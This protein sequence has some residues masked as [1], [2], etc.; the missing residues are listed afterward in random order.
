M[1][2]ISIWKILV[3]QNWIK[4]IWERSIVKVKNH[5]WSQHEKIDFFFSISVSRSLSNEWFAMLL[6]RQS[7][8]IAFRISKAESKSVSKFHFLVFESKLQSLQISFYFKIKDF[9]FLFYNLM[10]CSSGTTACKSFH[11]GEFWVNQDQ[12]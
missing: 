6:L 2:Q 7:W 9:H 4:F 11:T 10:N 5:I 3:K 1:Q 8:S 12:N